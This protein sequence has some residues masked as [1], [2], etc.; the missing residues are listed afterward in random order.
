MACKT[1]YSVYKITNTCINKVYIG[2]DTYFPR[3]LNQHKN[4]LLKNIHKNKHLQSSYNKYGIENFSFELL[5]SCCSREEML[6]KEI[7]C[8]AD[9]QSIKNGYNH[10]EGGEGSIGFKHS[11]ETKIKM[12]LWKRNFT[13]LWRDNLS[14]ASKGIAKN[15]GTKRINHP[16]YSNWLGGEK[17]PVSKLSF[18][19]I[20]N[21]RLEFLNGV[22]QLLIAKEYNVS[23]T[24]INN[25]VLNKSWKDEKYIYTSIRNNKN[26]EL[27]N[28]NKKYLYDTISID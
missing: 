23:K 1:N 15:K 6:K 2:V 8:I 3:R 19:N 25:I 22:S 20:C 16:N 10:T 18:N 9:Y 4:F 17:H 12:S 27:I 11:E 7:E 5:F 21:I 24:Q 14:K 28:N 13:Q 26:I